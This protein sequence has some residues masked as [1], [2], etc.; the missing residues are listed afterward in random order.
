VDVVRDGA[1]GLVRERHV[2]RAADTLSVDV[3]ED[4]G[5]AA[6]ARRR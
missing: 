2:V 3:V 5:F 4:G 6:V 1:S